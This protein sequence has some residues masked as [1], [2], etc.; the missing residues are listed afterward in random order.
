MLF[1]QGVVV[2]FTIIVLLANLFAVRFLM[3]QN[4]ALQIANQKWDQL[5]ETYYMVEKPSKKQ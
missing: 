5:E 4:R 1:F 3:R 2:G